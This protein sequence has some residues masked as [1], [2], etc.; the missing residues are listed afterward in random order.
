[1]SRLAHYLTAL[2][3]RAGTSWNTFWFTPAT[4]LTNARHRIGAGLLAILYLLT[5]NMSLPRWF[6]RDGLLPPELVQGLLTALNPQDFHASP[7][8]SLRSPTELWAYHA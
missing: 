1:M 5:W 8:F 2:Y 6:A 3:D 4:P 7:L